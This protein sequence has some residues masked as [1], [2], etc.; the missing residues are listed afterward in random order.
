MGEVLMGSP[1]DDTVTETHLSSETRCHLAR[2]PALQNGKGIK[3]Q[4]SRGSCRNIGW[5][6]KESKTLDLRCQYLVSS[7]V[8]LERITDEPPEAALCTVCV[9][10]CLGGSE[11]RLCPLSSLIQ[12]QSPLPSLPLLPSSPCSLVHKHLQVLRVLQGP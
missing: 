11:G 10:V 2:G 8:T 7:L 12:S 4:R 9:Q 3:P 6:T 1:G 5:A